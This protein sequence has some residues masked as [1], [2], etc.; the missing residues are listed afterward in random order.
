MFVVRRRSS[1]LAA[2]PNNLLHRVLCIDK[3]CAAG[4]AAAAGVHRAASGSCAGATGLQLHMLPGESTRLTLQAAVGTLSSNRA[5]QQ[6]LVLFSHYKPG[7]T[8]NPVSHCCVN[9]CRLCA[10]LV[11]V[12]TCVY[13]D[14]PLQLT[15]VLCAGLA[16]AAWAAWQVWMRPKIYLLD[17]V[18]KRPDDRYIALCLLLLTAGS[19][20]C[21]LISC[22]GT[23]LSC[24]SP[25]AGCCTPCS[26]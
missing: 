20:V 3:C 22:A 5:Q 11:C 13:S 26:R 19:W 25:E 15:A 1:R 9:A 10:F 7:H 14:Q 16:L 6:T 24:V 18:A 17:F 8:P 2:T 23:L 12:H 21:C 4:Q